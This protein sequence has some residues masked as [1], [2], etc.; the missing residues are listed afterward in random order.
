MSMKMNRVGYWLVLLCC[1][2]LTLAAR[3][4]PNPSP[5]GATDAQGAIDVVMEAPESDVLESVREVSQDHIIHGTYVYEREKTL[6]GAHDLASSLAL[7]SLETP[8]KVLYKQID[9]VVDPRHFQKSNGLGA[10]T[11]RYVVQ[12][13][14]PERTRLRIDAVFTVN[15]RH[16]SNPSDG[17]VE[18]AEYDEIRERLQV[19]QQSRSQLR[20]ELPRREQPVAVKAPEMKSPPLATTLGDDA[21]KELEQRVAELRSQ[22]EAQVKK[23][24]TA[25]RSAPFSGAAAI[26]YLPAQTA[27]VILVLTPKWYGV[28]GQ[29]GHRGWIRCSELV[30]QP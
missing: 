21:L 13:V 3:G 7:G 23:D 20:A 2:V 18:S 27:V 28:E 25:L 24:G 8:G 4:A 12:A 15:D 29:D 9:N 30:A 14:S 6:T 5:K 11:V 22:V 10:I 16:G 19:L 26:K 1:S 17:T